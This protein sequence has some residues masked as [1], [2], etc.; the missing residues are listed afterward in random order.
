MFIFLQHIARRYNFIVLSTVQQQ[1]EYFTFC[2]QDEKMNK[3][4]SE[5]TRVIK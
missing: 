1:P 3:K 2:K 5:Q 4:K